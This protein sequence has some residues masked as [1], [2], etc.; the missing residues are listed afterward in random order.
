MAGNSM[1]DD[2]MDMEGEGLSPVKSLGMCLRRESA[3]GR[4]AAGVLSP[5]VAPQA[6]PR[7][8]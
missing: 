6:C 1:S 7:R 5:L 4:E 2:S 8:A 3:A